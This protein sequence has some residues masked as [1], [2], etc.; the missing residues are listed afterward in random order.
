[1]PLLCAAPRLV[2]E[3]RA[4]AA[5]DNCRLVHQT[6]EHSSICEVYLAIANTTNASALV[7][8]ALTEL[9]YLL[10]DG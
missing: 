1:M 5:D 9:V 10:E 3:V 8:A 6:R 4:G 7:A 2:I